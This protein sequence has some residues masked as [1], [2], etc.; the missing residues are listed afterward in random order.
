MQ[1]WVLQAMIVTTDTPI[2]SHQLFYFW[3]IITEHLQDQST[4]KMLD[5]YLKTKSLVIV[6]QGLASGTLISWFVSP[7]YQCDAL[8]QVEFIHFSCQEIGPTRMCVD[9]WERDETFEYFLSAEAMDGVDAFRPGSEHWDF[10]SAQTHSLAHIR[11]ARLMQLPLLLATITIAI[12]LFWQPVQLNTLYMQPHTVY[13]ASPIFT[14]SANLWWT[15]GIPEYAN[16]N[17]SFWSCSV[18]LRC[19]ISVWS[20]NLPSCCWFVCCGISA[21][22]ALKWYYVWTGSCPV[23]Y[24]PCLGK[25]RYYSCVLCYFMLVIFPICARAAWPIPRDNMVW[26][27]PML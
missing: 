23:E 16:K 1:M 19:T 27:S 3:I 6:Q 26:M 22:S 24:V 15:N 14:D 2:L 12:E 5:L 13:A 7:S 18:N 9:M 4:P 21:G 8:V 17:N 20:A 11:Q 25:P 10:W